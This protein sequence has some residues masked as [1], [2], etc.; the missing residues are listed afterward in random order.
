MIDGKVPLE[1]HTDLK[2]GQKYG[3]KKFFN[4]HLLQ[5]QNW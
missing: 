2:M 5:N 1:Y 3:P 4:N